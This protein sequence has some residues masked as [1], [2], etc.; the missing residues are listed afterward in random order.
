V[1][2]TIAILL[3]TIHLFYLAGRVLFVDYFIHQNNVKAEGQIDIGNY[4]ADQL[5]EIK[6]PLNIPYYSSSPKYERYYGEFDLDGRYYNYVMRKVCNDTIYL[7]CLADYDRSILNKAK[8]EFALNA[9]DMAGCSPL[10]K[11]VENFVKKYA[12]ATEYFHIDNNLKFGSLALCFTH[13]GDIF[14]TSLNAGFVETPERPP[15]V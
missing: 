8:E 2:K 3:I 10:K 5:I 1:K 12:S 11:S 13:S 14:S 4:D 6:V 7:L 9:A 15:A